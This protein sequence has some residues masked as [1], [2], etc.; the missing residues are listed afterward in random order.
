MINPPL[1]L[2]TPVEGAVATRAEPRP[3]RLVRHISMSSLVAF[4][5]MT[6]A[7][8][9]LYRLRAE[10][11]LVRIE[12]TR[13]AMFVEAIYGAVLDEG[14]PLAGATAGLDAAQLRA[15]PLTR[16]LGE[17]V[18]TQMAANRA[19]TRV[20]LYGRDGR[21]LFANDEDQIGEGA[22]PYRARRALDGERTVSVLEQIALTNHAGRVRERSL[23]VS[24]VPLRDAP[25]GAVDGVF[26]VFSDVT[27]VVEHVRHTQ[28]EMATFV[29]LALALLYAVQF[30]IV[31]RADAI[32]RRQARER[33]RAEEAL[34][35]AHEVLEQ[36]VHERTAE[37]SASNTRLRQE[38]SERRRAEEAAREN[39]Q[40]FRVQVEHSPDAIVV[41]EAGAGA[42][43]EA[44]AN[45]LRLFG[46]SAER[47]SGY[48]LGQLSP[49]RQSDGSRSTAL[50]ADKVRQALCDGTAVLDWTLRAT[51]GSEV[52]TEM[53][54]APLPARERPLILASLSD[55]RERK[56]TE[57][58]LRL[59]A[60][61]FED[62]LDGIMI[63]DAQGVILRVNRAF[64]AITG[65]P[66]E[67]AVGQTPRLL[68]SDRHDGAFF[69]DLWTA[70]LRT[71][72]WKGEI[73]N[74]RRSGEVYPECR[75]ISAVLDSR[76]VVSHYISVFTDIS[77]KKLSEERLHHL[78][79]YD[80][81]TELP[82]RALFQERLAQALESASGNGRAVALLFVDL[83]RFKLIN[84]TYGHPTGDRLLQ[85]VAARLREC[86]RQGD[87]VARLAGD[88]FTV[89]LEGLTPAE[90]AGRA[91]RVAQKLLATLAAPFYL[92]GHEM[93][94]TTSIGISLF[95]ADGA[96]GATL[97][98][99]ADTALYRVKDSG[100]NGLRFFTE[101]MNA[102]AVERLALENRLR[103]AIE[104]EEL[105]LHYQPKVSL[106]SGRV[107]GVEAL[108][109][110]NDP[111]LGLV[112]PA[113]FIPVAE[114]TGLIMS[115]GGWVMQQACTQMRVWLDAGHTDLHIAVNLSARQFQD[116]GLV[117]TV[118]GALEAS[119]I[120]PGSL[121]L[122]LTETFIM[123]N[124]E[125][126]I[127]I[128]RTLKEM[129]VR[130]SVDDFG[131]GYSSLSYLKRFPIDGVKIDRSF[132]Q[133]TPADPDS[134]AITSAIIALGHRLGLEVVAEGV[135]TAVQHAFLREH[136]CQVGQ[137]ELFGA[138]V[139]AAACGEV[140]RL[141]LGVRRL[142]GEAGDKLRDSGA[143]PAG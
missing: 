17:A 32:L 113:K 124:P 59:A 125:E 31:K 63:T 30:V 51:D 93:F 78:A 95:P 76:G 41:F 105:V 33:T 46:L 101:D 28:Q 37:L 65:Y 91:R 6:T 103:H 143:A 82:N 115:I 29:A 106:A 58:E 130:L 118:A 123:A 57:A 122:E 110:W 20:T 119:G 4:C 141:G 71:R 108:L 1:A 3:F 55:I 9:G 64:T 127:A 5:L 99:N 34:R 83:D 98:R 117:Q 137:G 90:A 136:G 94:V 142:P 100:K 109:R 11:D 47:L 86:T 92:E 48:T 53:R 50:L 16:H 26:E 68:R 15:H 87:T 75:S 67:E 18:R 74:R 24:Y 2:D 111:E 126:S 80:A 121:E 61:V 132:L 27:P 107:Q 21:V 23:L 133:D 96:D 13:H 138:P 102:A 116:P 54:L 79:H 135:E 73:W 88:E 104:H 70:L 60:S 69:R 140:L 14:T 39:A 19:V 131:I 139:A 38:I 49:E 22:L 8:A 25:A 42:L 45:A 85:G 81:L 56:R 43:L 44:N 97:L 114:E 7:L 35:R 89:L 72:Q 52:V 128:L 112:P 12:E 66:P 36:R 40:R 62:G 134:A 129:G 120:P 84:D 77:D 10:A